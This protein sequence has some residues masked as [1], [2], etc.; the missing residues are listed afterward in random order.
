MYYGLNKKYL[1]FNI[2]KMSLYSFKKSEKNG[3]LDWF[4]ILLCIIRV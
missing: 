4:Y 2:Y 3:K 1:F